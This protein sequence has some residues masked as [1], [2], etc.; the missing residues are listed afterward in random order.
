MCVCAA[1]VE[2]LNRAWCNDA[3]FIRLLTD[4]P[5]ELE[6]GPVTG[7]GGDT[8][9]SGLRSRGLSVGSLI[10]YFTLS[11]FLSLFFKLPPLNRN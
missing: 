4:Y 7:P 1:F 9:V 5:L 8:S 10:H 3:T 2:L 6:L 11:P